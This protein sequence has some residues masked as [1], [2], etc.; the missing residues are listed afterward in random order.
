M[1]FV[2]L[3]PANAYRP[4]KQVFPVCSLIGSGEKSLIA[5]V[6]GSKWRIDCHDYI[7]LRRH[8]R[9]ANRIEIRI[10]WHMNGRHVEH[11]A[12]RTAFIRLQSGGHDLKSV[13]WV[14]RWQRCKHWHQHSWHAKHRKRPKDPSIVLVSD[15]P[16]SIF[17]VVE[18]FTVRG[19]VG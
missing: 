6:S 17:A 15:V 8:V 9:N 16:A 19:R 1:A 10:R 11:T 13:Q 7:M 5:V 12:H 4:C 18:T 2:Y 3:L 14:R